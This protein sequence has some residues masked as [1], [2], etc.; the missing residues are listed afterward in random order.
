MKS[1]IVVRNSA[2]I[3]CL[4]DMMAAAVLSPIPER[5]KGEVEGCIEKKGS[6]LSLKACAEN[7]SFFSRGD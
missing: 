7:S 2:D 5:K 3:A 4:Q 1:R 6:A